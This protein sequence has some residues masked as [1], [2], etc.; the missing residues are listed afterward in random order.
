MHIE[1]LVEEESCAAF[2]KNVAPQLL[3]PSD[4]FRVHTFIGKPDLLKSLP[5]RLNA[6]VK[7]LPEDYRI[8]VLVDRDNDDCRKLKRHLEKSASEAGLLTKTAAKHKNRF[9]VLNRILVEELESWFFGDVVALSKAYPGVPNTLAAQK[10]FRDPDAIKGGTWEALER[11]LQKAGYYPAG[12]PKIE[13]ARN[14]SRHMAPDRNRSHSFK[15][16]R[17]TIR[18]MLV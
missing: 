5:N 6:Y 18:G 3:R 4:E 16:F 9:K 2:L 1:F 11:V 15:V 14:V 10:G 12:I 7:W 13:V 8:V 17:D